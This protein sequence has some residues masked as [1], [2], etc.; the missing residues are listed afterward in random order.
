[1][2]DDTHRG[3]G[4]RLDFFSGLVLTAVSLVALIWVIPA[5][6]PGEASSGEVAPSF[7]P[8][9]TAGVVLVCSVALVV[10]NRAAVNTRL[11]PEGWRILA[12]LAGW[13]IFAVTLWLMLRHL[14]FVAASVIAT[15]VFTLVSRYRGRLWLVGLIA[16]TL[17]VA[18]RFGVEALFG[19][20]LP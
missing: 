18:L 7:F 19:I 1:M 4:P 9:L 12:E 11:G 15:A 13:T 2:S 16:I 14:G 17:P 10:A 8:N 20:N 5:A 3:A 6:V